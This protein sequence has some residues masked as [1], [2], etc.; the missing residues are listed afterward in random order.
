M[1][2]GAFAYSLQE[3]HIEVMYQGFYENGKEIIPPISTT[4]TTTPFKDYTVSLI[5]ASLASFGVGFAFFIYNPQNSPIEFRDRSK[6]Q[7]VS[8]VNQFSQVRCGN[9]G[10]I[11]DSD[12]VYCKKCGIKFH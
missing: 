4:V 8:N 1:L 2:A 10:N 5:L 6:N 7:D 9:C 12:A 3:S 11:I